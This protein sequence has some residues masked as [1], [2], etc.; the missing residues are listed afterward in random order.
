[1]RGGVAILAR[2]VAGARDYLRPAHDHGADRRFA[3]RLR[4]PRLLERGA[5]RI[6][7]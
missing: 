6:H 2:A 3:A 7:A 1:M 4:R 5:H